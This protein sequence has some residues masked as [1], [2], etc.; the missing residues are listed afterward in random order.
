[1]KVLRELRE[2]DLDEPDRPARDV[3]ADPQP[4]RRKAEDRRHDL[5]KPLASSGKVTHLQVPAVP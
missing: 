5:E 2:H 3:L 1:M 4:H